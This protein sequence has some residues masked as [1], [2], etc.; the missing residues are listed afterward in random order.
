MHK[1]ILKKYNITPELPIII[2]VS[3]GP[4]S[5][6]L[7]HY[8][9]TN[10][11]NP[12]VVAHINHNI[13][14]ESLEEQ[15]Y[16][17][18]Y[19]QQ[20]NLTFELLTITNYQET[21][22]ENEARQK[23]YAFYEEILK[24]Y[25][26]QYL[27]LAHHGD[28]QI[29][30]ILMKITRGSNIEGYAGIKEINPQNNYYIIRP[31]LHL[32]KQDLLNYNHQ[33]NI[34]YYLDHTNQ[35][36][37]YTRNRYRK[38]ILPLLKKED[39]YVHLKFQ[40]FS[41]TLLEYHNYLTDETNQKI[42]ELYQNNQ[43]QLPKFYPLHPLLKKQILYTIL[44]NIYKN[45]ITKIKENH[46]H[47]LLTIINNPKPNLTINLP[48]NIIAKKEYQTLTFIKNNNSPKQSYHL[49]LQNN[50]QIYQHHF[51]IIDETPEDGNNICR[52]NTK[53]LALPLYIRNKKDGDYIELKGITGTKKVKEIFIEKKL[54]KDQRTN[55]PILVDKNDTILWI[56][57][58]KKTKFTLKKQENYDIIIKYC[59][60]G[61]K[62]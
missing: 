41:E 53:N 17:K 59:E 44:Q 37:K 55:Y 48:N 23:R 6:A 16:L 36:T 25:N 54:S 61:G 46:I 33:N 47:N 2:G 5:M 14:K 56:P 22:F 18:N 57:N 52:L 10:T 27:F 20:N 13:R 34:K 31:F 50:T 40:K 28:D 4:D 15:E 19:C 7:L 32:T 45:N 62:Q 11:S 21:N 8:L 43:L 24:K 35:D 39:P 51:S 38:N 26:S 30:T 29:E 60:R 12:L 9:M 3:A 42:Q 58:L 49:K 1:N